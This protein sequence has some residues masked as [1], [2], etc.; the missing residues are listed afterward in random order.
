MP[1][2]TRILGFRAFT[3]RDDRIVHLDGLLDVR[4][5]SALHQIHQRRDRQRILRQ[6]AQ[7]LEVFQALPR[8]RPNTSFLG[9]RAALGP[10]TK[11]TPTLVFE[12]SIR[13]R[14][15]YSIYR[16]ILHCQTLRQYLVRPTTGLPSVA[17]FHD[18]VRLHAR[19]FP[20]HSLAR[21]HES[22]SSTFSFEPIL[23]GASVEFP[24]VPTLRLTSCS[25]TCTLYEPSH[26]ASSGTQG[27]PVCDTSAAP[28]LPQCACQ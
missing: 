22:L 26:A 13:L 4:N 12:V 15:A 14:L 8:H 24:S 7:N 5:S 27:P 21:D 19:R 6:Q 2:A 17:T 3:L 16:G 20:R 11:S 28:S 23:E 10:I 18:V 1:M 25:A 9:Q